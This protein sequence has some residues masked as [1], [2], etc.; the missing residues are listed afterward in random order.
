[1]PK[2]KFH[3]AR[4][5]TIREGFYRVIDAPSFAEANAAAHNLAR[6]FNN[7]CPDDCSETGGEGATSFDVEDGPKGELIEPADYKI[8]LDG[9]CRPAEGS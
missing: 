2:Y 4:D 3:F 1:M 7:D 8:G 9:Q 5:Y 6:E